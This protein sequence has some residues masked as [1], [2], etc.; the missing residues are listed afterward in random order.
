MNKKII[1]YLIIACALTTKAIP[2]A[3]RTDVNAVD[4]SGWTRLHLAASN[5]NERDV[6]LLIAAGADVD[7]Q[8]YAGC[9]PLLFAAM[10]GYEKIVA[11][12]LTKADMSKYVGWTPLHTAAL[13]GHFK[14]VQLLVNAGADINAKDRNDRTPFACAR[15]N[16]HTEIAA[17]LKAAGAL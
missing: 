11:L 2:A 8:N 17:F 15:E 6:E 16:G 4:N 9:T 1:I 13:N 10:H 3:L 5:N 12:L 7:A 14:C